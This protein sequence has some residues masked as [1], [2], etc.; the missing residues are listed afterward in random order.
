MDGGDVGA[1]AEPL[2]TLAQQVL[3]FY[4]TDG[5]F[6][7]FGPLHAE[8]QRDQ[9]WL[10]WLEQQ[11]HTLRMRT[12]RPLYRAVHP[13]RNLETLK[14]VGQDSAA[15]YA[16]FIGDPRRFRSTRLFRGW[17][18]MVPD[19]AQSAE[20]EA[21]GL[22]LSQ[23]GPDLIKKF[24]YL[25]AEIARRYDPQIAAIYYDQIMHK[26]KHHKQAV[27][28][29][30][31]HLLDRVLAVLRSDKAYM[32][33]DV[34]GTPV[35]GQQARAIIVERYSVHSEVRRRTNKRNRRARSDQRAE[36]QIG[37]SARAATGDS[38]RQ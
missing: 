38:A 25:D 34:D 10:T 19:S 32:L 13:S 15:V 37:R 18:G 5:Q 24:A 20:N 9:A 12:V 4:G 16:G 29:C 3:T 2:L 31:T 11:H 22:H 14:G 28:A 30:A 23:A 27:C 6:L 21:K 26:G 35:S 8:V 33:R 17:T 7:D 36:R 1:W